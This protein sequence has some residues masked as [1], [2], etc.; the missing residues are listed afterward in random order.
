[1]E[2]SKHL[3]TIYFPSEQGQVSGKRPYTIN[4]LKEGGEEG[5]VQTE[6]TQLDH[7]WLLGSG[8]A[9]LVWRAKCY[10]ETS[11]RAGGTIPSNLLG[12]THAH[13]TSLELS[14]TPGPCT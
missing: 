8:A 3:R 11:G 4:S 1:M 12:T 9:S 13:Q 7:R 14:H 6:G 5:K 10:G 2:E